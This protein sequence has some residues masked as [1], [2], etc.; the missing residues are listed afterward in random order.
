MLSYFCGVEVLATSTS[1]LLSQQKYVI[2]LLSKHNMLG[3]KPVSTPLLIGTSLTTNDGIALVNATMYREVVGGLQH[4]RMTRLDI[5]FVMNKLSQFMHAP[6]EHHWGAIKRLFRYL[7]DMR[8][9]GIWLLANTPQTLHGFSYAD[10][11]GNQDDHTSIG[12][13]LIFLGANPI[14]WSSTK[15]RTVARF[16]AEAKY[17]AIAAAAAEL[18]WVKSLLSELLVPMQSPPTPFSDN[19]G[20]TYLSA[21]HIFH[22]RTKHLIIDYHLVHDL[23][24]SSELCVIHVSV[25]DQLADVLTKSLSRSRHFSL[26]NKIDVIYDTPS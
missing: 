2:E 26:C 7:N 9:L 16:S 1:L 25:G 14:S 11:V 18:Q 15:Q 17:R 19:L 6:S 5:S 10:W 8:S 20:A 13:F 23:V 4:L 24:Q 22:S 12:D 21:N 3:S